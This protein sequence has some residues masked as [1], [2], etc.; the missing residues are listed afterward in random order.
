[1][2]NCRFKFDVLAPLEFVFPLNFGV[3]NVLDV[4]LKS[5]FKLQC[6]FPIDYELQIVFKFS[7]PKYFYN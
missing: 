1:M 6:L 4:G 7:I 3:G 5:V 2:F